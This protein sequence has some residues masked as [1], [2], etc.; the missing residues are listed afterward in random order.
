MLHRASHPVALTC[1][2]G[3]F[4]VGGLLCAYNIRHKK[5]GDLPLDKQANLMYSIYAIRTALPPLGDSPKA[6]AHRKD[7]LA[8]QMEKS[9]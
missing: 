6:V 4:C 2:V 1:A 9:R 5:I 7:Y 3:I 8:Q